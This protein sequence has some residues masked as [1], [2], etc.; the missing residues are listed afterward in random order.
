MQVINSSNFVEAT[1]AADKPCHIVA[2]SGVTMTFNLNDGHFE[3]YCTGP[4]DGSAVVSLHSSI[5]KASEL[6]HVLRNGVSVLML[7][8]CVPGLMLG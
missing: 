5:Y 1:S 7:V 6:D 4:F 2:Q 3:R 8:P